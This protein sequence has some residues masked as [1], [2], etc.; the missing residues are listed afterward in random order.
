MAIPIQQFN[1]ETFQQ[2]NPMLGGIAASTQLP[3]AFAQAIYGPQLAQQQLL[4]QQLANQVTQAGLPYIGPQAAAVLATQQAMPGLYGAE[5]QESRARAGLTGQQASLLGQESPYLV[6]QQRLGMFTNPVIAAAA[7]LEYARQQG[8]MPPVASPSGTITPGAQQAGG[9]TGGAAVAGAIPAPAQV[10]GIAPSGSGAMPPGIQ[11]GAQS[12][13]DAL[14][15]IPGLAQVLLGP[16]QIAAY[17][18]GLSAQATTNVQQYNA[19]ATQAQS[20]TNIANQESQLVNQWKQA[21]DRSS[22]V[23]PRLGSFPSRGI[24]APP[25]QIAPEQE[26]DQSAQKLALLVAKQIAGGRLSGYMLQNIQATKP[27]RTLDPESAAMISDSFQA[28]AQQQSEKPS[29]IAAAQSMGVPVN[30]QRALWAQYQSQRAPYNFTTRSVNSNLLGT[31]GDFLTQQAISAAMNNQPY[32]PIPSQI[33]S[34]QQLNDWVATLPKQAQN[35]LQAQQ[36]AGRV[37]GAQ[38]APQQT[39]TTPTG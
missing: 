35:Y 3:T 38:T 5:A 17:G 28:L 2:A 34:K 20:D 30:V 24:L 1:P 29:F 11:P 14:Y 23:G 25:G 15:G 31:S 19:D 39:P 8:I 21:Y 4:Q 7:Q 10:A 33:T 12:S 32:V 36:I 16:Q 22:Y 13:L 9:P 18:A 26:A 27:S 6:Q 37:G